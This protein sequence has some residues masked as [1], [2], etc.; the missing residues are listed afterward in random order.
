[1]ECT[2]PVSNHAPPKTLQSMVQLLGLL[3]KIPRRLIWR[4]K[5]WIQGMWHYD[6][7]NSIWKTY[8]CTTKVSCIYQAKYTIF[9]QATTSSI[10]DWGHV[11]T[12]Y[13]VQQQKSYKMSKLNYMLH[14]TDTSSVLR[15]SSL[16]HFDWADAD[17]LCCLIAM[18]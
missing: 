4:K 14:I 10:N 6:R 5:Y 16:L 18:K 11:S 13:K 15:W 17:Y 8:D 2:C 12:G 7:T 9:V 3:Y 1:M